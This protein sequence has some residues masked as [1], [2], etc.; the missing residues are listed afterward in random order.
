MQ[1]LVSSMDA[2]SKCSSAVNSSLAD[3]RS[4]IDKLVRVRRLLKRLEFIFELPQRL[5]QSIELDT[6][7]QAV[8][9]YNMTRPLLTQYSHIPSFH[10]IE[11]ESQGIIAT[12]K[13][14]L[15]GELDDVS[16][17]PG[18]LAERTRLLLELQVP[19]TELR[20]KVLLSLIHI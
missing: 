17:A 3:T 7:E 2:I 5:R 16:I 12:L 18:R 8:K 9:Y 20:S 1:G 6:A 13:L 10:N 14:D 11:R 15:Q 4:N 19:R